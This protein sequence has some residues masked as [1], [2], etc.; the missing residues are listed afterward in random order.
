MERKNIVNYKEIQTSLD[1]GSLSLK[2]DL[3]VMFIDKR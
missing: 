3:S 2:R 1:G